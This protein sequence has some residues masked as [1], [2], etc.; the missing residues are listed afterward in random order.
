MVCA[1]TKTSLVHF[2][3]ASGIDLIWSTPTVRALR[4]CN[5]PGSTWAKRYSQ[6]YQTTRCANIRQR[7]DGGCL[8]LV[9]A[10]V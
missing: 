2:A 5:V 7:S 8:T 4:C 10:E 6:D 9:K 3:R 1:A